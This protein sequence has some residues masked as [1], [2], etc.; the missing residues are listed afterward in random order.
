MAKRPRRRSKIDPY[1][2]QVGTVPDKEIAEL[3]GTSVENVRI[4]RK[5]RGIPARWRKTDR[6]TSTSQSADE[7]GTGAFGS[8]AAARPGSQP[9]PPRRRKSKL[10]PYLDQLGLLPDEEVANLAGVTVGNVR[11]YRYRHGIPLARKAARSERNRV[12]PLAAPRPALVNA[13]EPEDHRPPETAVEPPPS[14]PASAKLPATNA[15]D[16][17]PSPEV[18]AYRIKV[19]GVG[20]T[21]AYVVIAKD[22]AE[23]A[24]KAISTLE[25]RGVEGEVLS[26]KYLA[27]ALHR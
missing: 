16:D 15:M 13:P 10:D 20:G 2:E 19:E 9:K 24:G 4:Y 1:L 7:P 23:A 27:A 22:I 11:A 17:S 14:S 21:V 3:A 26:V 6:S 12:D 5:R 25:Q 8:V 18:K